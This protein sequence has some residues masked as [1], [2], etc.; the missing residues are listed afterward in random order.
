ME[1]YEIVKCIEDYTLRLS[2]LE[3]AVDLMD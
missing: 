2:E 3:K 1:N